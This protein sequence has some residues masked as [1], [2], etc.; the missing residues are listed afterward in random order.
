MPLKDLAKMEAEWKVMER[1]VFYPISEKPL[2][3]QIS[4]FFISLFRTSRF[5]PLT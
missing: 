3:A 4:H 2:F 1:V 5:T